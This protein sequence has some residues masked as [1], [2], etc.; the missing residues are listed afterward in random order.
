MAD[1]EKNINDVK[2]HADILVQNLNNNFMGPWND[3]VAKDMKF[4]INELAFCIRNN[5]PNL[6]SE[7][8]NIKENLFYGANF[9]NPFALGR[10][11]QIMRS[12]GYMSTNDFWQFIHPKVIEL[13]KSKFEDGY[14]SDA[15]QTA[16]VEICSI[17]REFRKKQNLPE[18]PSDKDMLY[19]TFSTLKVLQ[20]TD[21]STASLKNIQEGYEKI[22][23]GVIQAMRNPNAHQNNIIEKSEAVQKLMI[24]SNLMKMLDISVNNKTAE[25]EK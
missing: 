15:V 3:K 4:Y 10:L 17:V 1:I 9:V 2:T 18:I 20:F 24:A 13:C 11:V 8:Q 7:L 12:Y 21:S 16:L 5:N 6:Y 14:Y 19:N 22:F 23:P 25:F